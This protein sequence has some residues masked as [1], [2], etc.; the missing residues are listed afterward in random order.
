M[1]LMSENH[2]WWHLISKEVKDRYFF[3]DSTTWFMMGQFHTL[4]LYL[5]RIAIV[6]VGAMF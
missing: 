3:L 1:S 2:R 6:F 5:L 4:A